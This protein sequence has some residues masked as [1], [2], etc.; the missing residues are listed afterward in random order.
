M[1][2]V[3]WLQEFALASLGGLEMIVVYNNNLDNSN[4]L[5]TS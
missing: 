1:D 4:I 2:S 5:C 3:T